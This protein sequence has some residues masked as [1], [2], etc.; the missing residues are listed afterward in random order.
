MDHGLS[1]VPVYISGSLLL[2]VSF[3]LLFKRMR[4]KSG[5]DPERTEKMLVLLFDVLD[6]FLGIYSIVGFSGF[7]EALKANNARDL[8][9]AYDDMNMALL[10]TTAAPVLI[11]A[12][13][14]RRS[15]LHSAY[16]VV[17]SSI[18]NGDNQWV[19]DMLAPTRFDFT[20]SSD[21]R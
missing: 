19:V 10:N 1:E 17:T 16:D 18:G 13:R 14:E 2:V 15:I 8:R 6:L 20:V 5:S 3:V 12:P 4:S 11:V 21:Y 9:V 7:E